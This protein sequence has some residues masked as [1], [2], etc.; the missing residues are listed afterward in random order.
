MGGEMAVLPRGH[1]F[2]YGEGDKWSPPGGSPYN[3]NEEKMNFQ[4]IMNQVLMAK[5]MRMM[6]V[7]FLKKQLYR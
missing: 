3:Y 1:V 6:S 4:G 5:A 2:H 7:D